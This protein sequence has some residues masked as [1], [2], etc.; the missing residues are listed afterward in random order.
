MRKTKSPKVKSSSVKGLSSSK[1]KA[2]S[3]L[4]ESAYSVT[5]QT[6]CSPVAAYNS[7]NQEIMLKLLN[8]LE[9][10]R[11]KVAEPPAVQGKK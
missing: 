7:F 5:M 1:P 4:E 8:I 3:G 11:D 6:V 10:D 2:L 9:K